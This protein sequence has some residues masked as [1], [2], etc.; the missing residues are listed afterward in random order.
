MQGK[1]MAGQRV[2]RLR[3][4]RGL[5]QARMAAQLGISTSYLNLIERSQRPVT[6]PFLLRLGQAFDVDL[7]R[8]AEDDEGRVTAA[9]REVFGDPLFARSQVTD[10]D[11]RDAAQASPAL[12]DAVVLLFRAYRD[13]LENAMDPAEAQRG[14]PAPALLLR[15]RRPLRSAHP[16]TRFRRRCRPAPATS[17]SSRR[18]P[19][20]SGPRPASRPTASTRACAPFSPTHTAS[21][22]VSCLRR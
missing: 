21:G 10:Q 12:G 8:F 18:P 11:I 2:R 6:V 17:T 16:A 7:Q 19:S 22:C 15:R 14:S 9:L 1:L 20:G 3:R 4:E 5:T 13:L